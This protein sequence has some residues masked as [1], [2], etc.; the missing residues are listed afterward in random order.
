MSD[1]SSLLANFSEPIWEAEPIMSTQR[2]TI[3][4]TFLSEA[5]YLKDIKHPIYKDIIAL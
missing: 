1:P 4:S 3:A 5:I 2:Q